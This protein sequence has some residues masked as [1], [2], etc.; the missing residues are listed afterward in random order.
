MKGNFCFTTL[1][2]GGGIS[3]VCA[4][5]AKPA[6]SVEEARFEIPQLIRFVY[7]PALIPEPPYF[8]CCS[9]LFS[10]SETYEWSR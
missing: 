6:Q 5:P 2:H 8:C 3:D 1:K 10:N 7:F 4:I 9:T